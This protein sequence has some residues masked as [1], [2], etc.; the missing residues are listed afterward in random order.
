MDYSKALKFLDSLVNYEQFPKATYDFDLESYKEFLKTIGSPEKRLK[1]VILVAG[2]K[3]KGSTCALI[4]SALRACGFKTGLYTSPHLL[5]VRERIKVSGRTIGEKS[6]AR[7]VSKVAPVIKN[8]TGRPITYFEAL[9]AIA[10]LYFEGAVTDYTILEVGLGGRLDATNATDPDIAVIT[11][12]GFDH[13]EILGDTLPKIAA[14]KAGI[15]HDR[16]LVVSAPQETDVMKIIKKKC[17]VTRSPLFLV[18][19]EAAFEFQRVDTSGCFFL[20]KRPWG[21]RWFFIPLLGSHQITNALTTLVVLSHLN[22]EVSKPNILPKGRVFDRSNIAKGLARTQLHARCE[23]IKK[24]P[25]ILLDT[26]HNSDSALALKNVLEEVFRN[27]PVIL[28]LGLSSD[29]PIKPVLETLLPRARLTFLTQARTPRAE[30]VKSLIRHARE[31]GYNPTL[32][33]TVKSALKQAVAA[34]KPEE[35]LVITGS[36]F[37]AAES[38]AWLESS[39]KTPTLRSKN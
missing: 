8:F 35:I 20:A 29:K 24:R 26:C 15:I 30:P 32:T 5:S 36:F 23:I 18:E 33:T 37:I 14:E 17:G 4:E 34:L 1:N 16:S 31:L 12:I 7:L 10:F 39:K 6:F 28:I 11:R 21:E 25:L 27:W 9:T 22:L 3:G 19:D 38:I 13:T 2:T